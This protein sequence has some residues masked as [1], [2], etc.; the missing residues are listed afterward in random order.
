[1]ITTDLKARAT[2]ADRVRTRILEVAAKEGADFVVGVGS[3]Q[4]CCA[5]IRGPGRPDMLHPGFFEA[6]SEGSL[7]GAVFG[8]QHKADDSAEAPY[9]GTGSKLAAREGK[10][11]IVGAAAALGIATTQ[12]KP[13]AWK[14]SLR[15]PADKRAAV[16]RAT[17]LLPTLGGLFK[18][19]RG[20]VFDGRA[21]AALI[22]LYGAMEQGRTPTAPVTLWEH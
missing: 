5:L 6:S 9:H 19:P 18:G 13:A 15:I 7:R 4:Q 12:V 14:K 11:L 22:A 17:Q 2:A 20:G 21:E 16:A 1:M 10:G 8:A 3:R